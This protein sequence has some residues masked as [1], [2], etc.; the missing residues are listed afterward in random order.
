M[1]KLVSWNLAHRPECWR[2][3][4]KTGADVALV[5]EACAPPPDVAERI[6]VDDAPWRTEGAGKKRSWRT[7]VVALNPSVALEWH[8]PR[9]ICDASA[10]ELALSRV[11]TV[12]AATLRDSTSNETLTLVSMYAAW[13]W[14]HT[15]TG[16]AWVYADASAHRLISDIS[17]FIG[18]QRGHRLIAAGDLNILCGHGEDGNQY[19]A[20]RYQTVFDRMRALGLTFVG[21]QSPEGRQAE[22]WPSELPRES[23]NVPTF[24]SN[25]QTPVTASR[26]L[27]FVFTSNDLASRVTA[28]ARNQPDEWGP[29][30]HSQVDI[31]VAPPT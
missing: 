17:V 13:E 19:W 31:F 3:L 25:R 22:P 6:V 1:L 16:S 20:G 11:G 12:A 27:D 8:V 24:H 9:S 29:S 28:R 10:G 15:S 18:Q 26:Q 21:P 30:D 4:L 14:A 2:A 7:A 23:R 5:Q